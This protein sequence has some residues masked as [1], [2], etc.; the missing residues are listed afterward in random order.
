MGLGEPKA[1]EGAWRG[2]PGRHGVAV[3]SRWPSSA[4]TPW[5]ATR[6]EAER[7]RSGTGAGW[8]NLGMGRRPGRAGGARPATSGRP[9]RNRGGKGE[10]REREQREKDGIDSKFEFFSKIS[11]ET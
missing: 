11:V 1:R 3:A 5:I 8:V 10:K 7:L 9:G 4:S 6:G 2:R